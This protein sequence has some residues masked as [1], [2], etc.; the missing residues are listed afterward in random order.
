MTKHKDPKDVIN[1][2]DISHTVV[3]NISKN[4]QFWNGK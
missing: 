2:Q 1:V 4:K 3:C